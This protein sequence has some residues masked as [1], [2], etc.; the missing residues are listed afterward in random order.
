[1]EIRIEMTADQQQALAQ[2][3]VFHVMENGNV[4][5]FSSPL[6]DAVRAATAELADAAAV[7]FIRQNPQIQEQVARAVE[8]AV[9]QAAANDARLG[10]IIRQAVTKGLAKAIYGDDYDD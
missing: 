9:T 3:A 8:H 5:A 6:A 1:M 4:S 7:E 2:H 10:T